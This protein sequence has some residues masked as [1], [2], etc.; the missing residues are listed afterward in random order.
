M[1]ELPG[2][3]TNVYDGPANEGT[4]L[5][6]DKRTCSSSFSITQCGSKLPD[7]G[8]HITSQVG[9]VSWILDYVRNALRHQ[10]RTPGCG[11]AIVR[12]VG[13]AAAVCAFLQP[14]IGMVQ[15]PLPYRRHLICSCITGPL[16]S[17]SSLLGN[18]G[19]AESWE[20]IQQLLGAGDEGLPINKLSYALQTA[21]TRLQ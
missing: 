19:D 16:R 17:F 21:V 5:G 20:V 12:S 18:E 11:D 1:A 15:A 2:F 14:C 4:H 10:I 13:C 7:R 9:M 8:Q 6:G 3:S